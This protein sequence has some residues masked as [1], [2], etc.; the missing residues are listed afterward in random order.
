MGVTFHF[1]DSN[2]LLQQRI[3][4]FCNVPSPHSSVVIADALR[5]TFND[6]G[7]MRKVFSIIVD[8]AAANGAAIE[9]LRD[10]FRLKGIILPVRGLFF[11]VRCCAHITNFLV[12]AGL[13]EIGDIIDFVR[14]MIKYRVASEKQL[15]VLSRPTRAFGELVSRVK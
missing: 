8:N 13:L 3:L 12:Q 5:E 4:N 7:I 6:W 11:H 14:Q 1:V 9:I 15:K 2:W 10:D